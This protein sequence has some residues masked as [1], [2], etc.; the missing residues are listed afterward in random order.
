MDLYITFTPK[1]SS[2]LIFL[3]FLLHIIKSHVSG[4]LFARYVHYLTD[5]YLVFHV[6]HNGFIYLRFE[7]VKGVNL[8]L[9]SPCILIYELIYVHEVVYK[10]TQILSDS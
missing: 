6:Y 4:K 7:V 10:L 3:S 5:F 1:I 8:E 2:S 9:F